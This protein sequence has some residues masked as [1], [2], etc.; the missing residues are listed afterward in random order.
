MGTVKFSAEQIQYKENYK[1]LLWN[2]ECEEYVENHRIRIGKPLWNLQK[3]DK[4]APD[5][6]IDGKNIE[7]KQVLSHGIYNCYGQVVLILNVVEFFSNFSLKFCFI[8][9]KTVY[10]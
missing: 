2:G 4:I 1:F 9:I 6:F 3:L 7:L 8:F 10:I 5:L